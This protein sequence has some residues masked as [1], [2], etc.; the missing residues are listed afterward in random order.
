MH[1]SGYRGFLIV[2][3]F[4]DAQQEQQS[5]HTN[6]DGDIDTETGF[7][8]TSSFAAYTNKCDQRTGN[9]GTK[10]A[11]GDIFEITL[12][13]L[14][15]IAHKGGSSHAT[16]TQESDQAFATQTIYGAATITTKG[17]GSPG[18]KQGNK[19]HT[20]GDYSIKLLFVQS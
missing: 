7:Y 19:C 6:Q 17:N 8:N 15:F 3:Y 18:K 1:R 11:Q 20:R 12:K 2:R 5:G 10:T 13:S 16:H 9:D 14:G 4:D